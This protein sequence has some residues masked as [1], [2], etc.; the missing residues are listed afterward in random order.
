[1]I[2]KL[3]HPIVPLRHNA[4]GWWG[5]YVPYG[6]RSRLAASVPKYCILF[7]HKASVAKIAESS[8]L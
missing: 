1:M 2:I 6:K 4:T 5:T 8:A 3:S 7:K